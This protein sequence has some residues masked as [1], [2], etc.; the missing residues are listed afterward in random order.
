MIDHLSSCVYTLVRFPN[1]MGCPHDIEKIAKMIKES[2]RKG[3]LEGKSPEILLGNDQMDLG[4][5]GD[6][7]VA[8]LNA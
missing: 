4:S 2:H 8:W 1:V 7:D 3:V 6:M 5:K